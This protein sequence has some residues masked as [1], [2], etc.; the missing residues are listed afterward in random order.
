MDAE[1]TDLAVV[2]D[3][4]TGRF[5]L[6][7]LWSGQKVGRIPAAVKLDIGSGKP[8][9]LMGNPLSREIVS[10]R[11]VEAARPFTGGTSTTSPC[12]SPSGARAGPVRYFVA[13]SLRVID[14]IRAEGDK[15]RVSLFE[16]VLDPKTVPDGCHMFRLKYQPTVIVVSASLAECLLDKAP[17]GVHI[18]P[19]QAAD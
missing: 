5:D 11:F 16:L 18:E 4:D 7:D 9:D 1:R 13:N 10:D 14:A 6:T 17:E 2:D 8:P 3:Y 12:R 15:E 19:V